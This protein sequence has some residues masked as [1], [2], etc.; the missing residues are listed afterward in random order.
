MDLTKYPVKMRLEQ[1][2]ISYVLLSMNENA[3]IPRESVSNLI[4]IDQNNNVVWVAEPPT[5]KYDIYWKIYFEDGKLLALSRLSI[6]FE[7]DKTSGSI[8]MSRLIK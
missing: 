2:D 5:T 4:A 6:L 8:L 1:G 3:A 7:I